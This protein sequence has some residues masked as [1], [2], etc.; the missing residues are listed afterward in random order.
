MIDSPSASSTG[1]S[2]II[3]SCSIRWSVSEVSVRPRFSNG[4]SS[5]SS[6]ETG[7]RSS[8]WSNIA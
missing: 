6:V 1:S 7:V 4:R 5:R 8:G 3:R 2:V